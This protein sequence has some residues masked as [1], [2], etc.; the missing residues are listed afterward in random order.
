M[1]HRV[2]I[3]HFMGR[4]AKKFLQ[5]TSGSKILY[6]IP[7]ELRK[8]LQ[9]FPRK[10]VGNVLNNITPS[11]I[12]LITLLPAQFHQNCKADFGHLLMRITGL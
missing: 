4:L 12:F 8:I 11:Y 3:G 2:V 7:L 6:R 10:V 9:T 1:G 5:L